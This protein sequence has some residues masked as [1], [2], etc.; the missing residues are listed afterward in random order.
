MGEEKVAAGRARP[1]LVLDTSVFISA[2]LFHGPTRRLVSLW[3]GDEIVFLV[4]SAVL[5][6]Y[7]RVLS[8]PKFRL[9]KDEIK[10][11]IEVEVMPFIEPVK[12]RTRLS[13]INTDPSDNKFLELAVDGKADAVVSSDT[14]LLE[15]KAYGG[16]EIVRVA[17][18]LGRLRSR[19]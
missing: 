2:L 11:L 5:K 8:Y 10:S 18:F 14:H 12:V 17:D 9:E 19:T 15:I 6:E 1:R 4:S 16:I 7:L 13:V 3:Q